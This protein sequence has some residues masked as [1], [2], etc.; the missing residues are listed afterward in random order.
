MRKQ[1]SIPVSLDEITKNYEKGLL[2]Q[3]RGFGVEGE[4]FETWVPDPDTTNSILNLAEAA[5]AAGSLEGLEVRVSKEMMADVCRDRLLDSLG[6]VVAVRI[7]DL[8]DSSI[9]H[10][11]SLDDLAVTAARSSK[12]QPTAAMGAEMAPA[13]SKK[14][15]ETVSNHQEKALAAKNLDEIKNSLYDLPQN[16]EFDHEGILEKGNGSHRITVEEGGRILEVQVN[17]RS[18]NIEK[19]AFRGRWDRDV[20]ALL[21]LMC[22]LV[23]DRPIQDMS[24]HAVG[25]LEFIV[26]G[27]RARPVPGITLPSA[28]DK[29]FVLINSFVRKVLEQYRQLTGY[30]ETENNFYDRIGKW[31][32]LLTHDKREEKIKQVVQIEVIKLGFDAS[33]VELV[34]IEYG[35]KIL[36]RFSGQMARA[37]VDKQSIMIQ[38]ER[39]LTE[40]LD[41]RLELFLEPLQDRSTLRRL[42]GDEE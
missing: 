25:R 17:L 9:I 16:D 22:E 31:W 29:R 3:L 32:T 33:E 21:D 19:A 2:T 14:V 24:D 11:S 10:L 42:S 12:V 1:E 20:A 6:G 7:E 4:L 28:V 38:L 13:I 41:S 27:G 40:H 23:E 36:I 37:S 26:R 5:I 30:Q 35:M 39:V 15:T 34:G 8:D 18:H